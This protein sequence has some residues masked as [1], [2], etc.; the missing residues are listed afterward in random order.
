MVYATSDRKRYVCFVDVGKETIEEADDFD[1]TSL[2]ERLQQ[3]KLDMDGS[4]SMLVERW[5]NY[6]LRA[7]NDEDKEKAAEDGDDDDES[8]EEDDDDD[9][10]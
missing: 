4:Q 10:E 8:G 3:A 1:V 2:R 9:V 6:L 5:K 7:T